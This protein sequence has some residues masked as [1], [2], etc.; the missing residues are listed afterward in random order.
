MN[1]LKCNNRT[2]VV[3]SRT[4][5]SKIV[6]RRRCVNTECEEY[7]KSH[8]T[9]ED[10][11]AVVP[12]VTKAKQSSAVGKKKVRVKTVRPVWDEPDDESLTDEELEAMIFG[13]GYE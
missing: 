3:D 12:K 6:R 8:K 4:I 5:D 11:M 13:G 2:T 7:N 9:V 10:W 1:C